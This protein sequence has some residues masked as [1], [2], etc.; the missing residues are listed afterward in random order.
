MIPPTLHKLSAFECISA[1]Q[2]C[3]RRGMEREAM[4]FAIE[5]ATTSQAF[6]TMMLNRLKVISQEDIGIANPQAVLFTEVSCNQAAE[7][8]RAG[9]G[10]WRLAV[11]NVILMLCRS[12]KSREADHFQAAVYWRAELE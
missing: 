3:I 10:A 2:K 11:A 9:K 5:L 7:W 8:Y 6:C 12:P 1:L 4:E